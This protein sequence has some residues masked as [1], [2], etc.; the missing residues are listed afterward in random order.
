MNSYY[1]KVIEKLKLDKED[2]KTNLQNHIV[3]TNINYIL[4]E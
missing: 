3:N 1:E 4:Q 2:Y